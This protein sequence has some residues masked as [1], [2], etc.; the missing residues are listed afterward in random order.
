MSGYSY[1]ILSVLERKLNHAALVH[2]SMAENIARAKAMGIFQGGDWST[3]DL[4]DWARYHHQFNKNLSDYRKKQT[5]N[6]NSIAPQAGQAQSYWDKAT[7][8]LTPSYET[9]AI[10]TRL[11]AYAD[12][13]KNGYADDYQ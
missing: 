2:K 8:E 10:L 9:K 3:E 1:P 12:K 5:E 11:V 4:K 13:L 7:K 6:G